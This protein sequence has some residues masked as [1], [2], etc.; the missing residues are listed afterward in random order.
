M[1]R[2]SVCVDLRRNEVDYLMREAFLP[3]PLLQRLQD[4]RWRSDA[5]GVLEISVTT[6]E[7]FRAAFTEQLAKVGFDKAY[8]PTKEGAVLEDLI[9]RFYA[10]S[11]R[12]GEQ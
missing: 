10:K 12:A 1:K 8:N 11:G 7:E 9:D 6:A 2:S 5:D 3:R 4:V